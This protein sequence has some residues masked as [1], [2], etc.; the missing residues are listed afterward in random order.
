MRTVRRTR[1]ILFADSGL[2]AYGLCKSIHDEQMN[3]PRS[4]IEYLEGTVVGS[5]ERTHATADLADIICIDT[6]SV[7]YCLHQGKRAN[8][9]R[10]DS[11][12]LFS[13]LISFICV[14]ICPLF[15]LACWVLWDLCFGFL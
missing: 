12:T 5:H 2:I 8:L 11:S 4:I 14:F 7:T 6:V 13:Y 9:D 15:L 3:K 10:F 1:P